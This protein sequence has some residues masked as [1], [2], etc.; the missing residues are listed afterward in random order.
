MF[1]VTGTVVND[2]HFEFSCSLHTPFVSKQIAEMRRKNLGYDCV[3]DGFTVSILLPP[4]AIV[5]VKKFAAAFSKTFTLWQSVFFPFFSE[6]LLNC[7]IF[8][9]KWGTCCQPQRPPSTGHVFFPTTSVE[10]IFSL[11][12]FGQISQSCSFAWWRRDGAWELLV[13]C[14]TTW[15]RCF[16]F[17]P[18]SGLCF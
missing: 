7:F 14:A 8:F 9:L 12:L 10:L 15:S 1:Y 18:Q 13:K 4:E 5:N 6:L 16:D 2:T 17:Q 3:L 11:P